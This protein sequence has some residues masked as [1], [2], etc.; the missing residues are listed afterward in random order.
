MRDAETTGI[1]RSDLPIDQVGWIAPG[2]VR[3]ALRTMDPVVLRDASHEGAFQ[4]DAAIRASAA[5]SVLCIPIV[6]QGR[7]ENLLYL[8]NNLSAGAFTPDR[9][10]GISLLTGQIAVSLKNAELY[11]ELEERI[12]E[13]TRQLELRNRFIRQA[14]GRY[15]SDDVAAALLESPEGLTLGGERR[16]VT[17]LMADLRGFTPLTDRLPP[18]QIV[19]IVNNFLGEMTEII[20]RYQGTVNE[21]I[22]DAILAIFGAPLRL[23]D[24]AERAVACAV[25]MQTAMGRVNLLNRKLGLPAVEMGVSLHTGDVVAGNVGSEKRAKYGVVGRAVN[26]AARI[27]SYTVGGQILA[28]EHTLALVSSPVSTAAEFVIHPKGI[29]EPLTVRVVEGIGGRYNLRVPAEGAAVTPLE[30]P[31]DVAVEVLGEG[32]Q[33][34]GAGFRPGVA[35]G[36]V[37]VRRDAANRCRAERF[38]EPAHPVAAPGR[39]RDLYFRQGGIG[40]RKR[41]LLCPIHVGLAGSAGMARLDSA[42]RYRGTTSQPVRSTTWT[43]WLRQRRSTPPSLRTTCPVSWPCWRMTSSGRPTAPASHWRSGSSRGPAESGISSPS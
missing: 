28:S 15:L 41:Y 12:A 7:V 26:V 17:I 13:R 40:R 16:Q 23:S 39:R 42:R 18:E 34:A 31:Q 11:E 32:P 1:Q 37:V 38:R 14:F 24:H 4:D 27:E 21:F 3:F 35:A 43:R 25:E 5:R 33:H 29:V 9:I 8:T 36:D 19:N 2:V 6:H 22:G 20:F 10:E 30:P